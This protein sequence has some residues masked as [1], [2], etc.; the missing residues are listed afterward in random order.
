MFCRTFIKY[1]K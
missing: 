1:T